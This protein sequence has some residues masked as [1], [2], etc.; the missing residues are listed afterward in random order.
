MISN[1][2]SVLHNH[3]RMI[4]IDIVTEV[5][6]ISETVTVSLSAVILEQYI[7]GIRFYLLKLYFLS[8]LI[9]LHIHK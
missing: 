5:T 7:R 6:A 3:N 1:Y 9:V 2:S 8:A 4:G